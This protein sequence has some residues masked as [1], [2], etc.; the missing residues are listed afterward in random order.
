MDFTHS[1]K[2]LELAE[3]VRA[4]VDDVIIPAEARDHGAHG[5]EPELRAELQA[6]A[7]AASLFAPHVGEELGGLGLDMRE[8]SLVFEE[9]GTSLLGPLAL[10]CAAPDE[11]NM[12]MLEKIASAE[13]QERYLVPLAAG[14]VRSCFAMTEPAPGAGSDPSML[15]T[16]ARRVDGGWIIDGDKWFITGA[17]GASFAIVMARTGDT[18]TRGRGATMFLVDA[19][20]PGWRVGRTVDCIDRV[21]PGGHAEVEL[22]DCFVADDA[23]LGE[24]G[25]GYQYAQVRLAPAR[26]THCMRWLGIAR[27]AHE[28][29]IDRAASRE[30]FGS[31]LSELGMI[32]QMIADSAIDLQTSRVM[33]W[34]TAWL[35]DTDADAQKASSMTKV[36]VAEAVNRVVD[37][38]VQICGSLGTSGDLPLARFFNEI[39]SFR[40]YDG[41]SEAHRWSI[42]RREVRSRSGALTPTG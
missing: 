9:A 10:N 23:I 15:R 16:T 30:G 14:L 28:I 26:L 33:I 35:L 38:A 40:I 17:E 19:E 18:I 42:A 39:R 37:R 22:K 36:H 2:T 1:P 12:A 21:A 27:R 7:R 8:Q 34:H 29:A 20:N 24:E 32:Q 11:G 31:R 4:F 13:Q 3:R 25:L 6:A 5:P 41:A